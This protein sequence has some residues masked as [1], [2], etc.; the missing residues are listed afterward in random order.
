MTRMRYGLAPILY[1]VNGRNE[2]IAS[3][4]FRDTDH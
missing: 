2:L 3:S 4:R 1:L